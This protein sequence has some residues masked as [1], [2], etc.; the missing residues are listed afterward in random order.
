[1]TERAQRFGLST[2]VLFS[3]LGFWLIVAYMILGGYALWISHESNR[4]TREAAIRA[5]KAAADVAARRADCLRSIPQIQRINDFLDGVSILV[6]V[7]E[8][9]SE[10]VV[11][12]T[13]P[14]DP[15]YQVRKKNLARLAIA[16]KRIDGIR[17]PIPTKH[18]CDAI[19]S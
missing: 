8:T 11:Q 14:T 15:Q 3:S 1:M 18:A 7:L 4:T 17:F 2:R 6:T 12:A 16:S 5:S 13:S 19:Q 10:A 9:N